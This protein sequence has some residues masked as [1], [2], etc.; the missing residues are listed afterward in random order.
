MKLYS[1]G[2]LA[3]LLTAVVCVSAARAQ[4]EGRAALRQAVEAMRRVPA[5]RATVSEAGASTAELWMEVVNPDLLHLRTGMGTEVYS[6]GKTILAREG[7]SGRF[8]EA[9]GN[10]AATV[11]I[12]RQMATPDALLAMATGVRFVSRETVNGTPA[13]VYAI[14]ALAFG[15]RVNARMWIADADHRPLRLEGEINGEAKLGAR[16]GRRVHRSAT[17]TYEYDPAIRVTMPTN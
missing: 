9:R 5:Y 3:A 4:E 16:T 14:D 8:A 1:R 13:S 15:M 11:A 10:V 2:L 12:A 7:A 6:D 17:V